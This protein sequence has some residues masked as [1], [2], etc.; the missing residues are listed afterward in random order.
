MTEDGYPRSVGFAAHGAQ[1][2]IG[3]ENLERG[4]DVRHV[5]SEP[6]DEGVV[7]LDLAGQF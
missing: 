6:L 5:G 3:R 4:V 1:V 2:K 7:V